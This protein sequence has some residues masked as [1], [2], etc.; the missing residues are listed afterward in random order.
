VPQLREA[1][2][3]SGAEQFNHSLT[4]ALA[5]QPDVLILDEPTNHLDKDNRRSLIRLLDQFYGTLIIAR[6]SPKVAVK[7]H[8]SPH[9]Q[10]STD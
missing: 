10:I 3:L 1:S 5:Q 6:S 2:S 8:F 7:I 4:Q 9:H